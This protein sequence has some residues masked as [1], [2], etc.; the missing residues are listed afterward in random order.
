MMKYKV[1]VLL[2]L[3]MIIFFNACEK[4]TKRCILAISCEGLSE[5]ECEKFYEEER[6]KCERGEF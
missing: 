1:K 4:K 6:K 2:I 5:K 3:S